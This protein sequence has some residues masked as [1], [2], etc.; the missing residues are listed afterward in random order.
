[1]NAYT[2]YIT[3]DDGLVETFG[4][5]N[6]AELIHIGNVYIAENPDYDYAIILE[7]DADIGAVLDAYVRTEPVA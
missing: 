1:M 7:P 3:G 6:A 2:L 4:S 5:N